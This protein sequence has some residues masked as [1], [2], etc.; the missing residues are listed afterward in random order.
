MHDLLN[1]SSSSLNKPKRGTFTQDFPQYYTEGIYVSFQIIWLVIQTLRG[2]WKG[3]NEWSLCHQDKQ[4]TTKTAPYLLYRGE[5]APDMSNISLFGSPFSGM[6][7][8]RPKS[9][10]FT[11]RYEVKKRIRSYSHRLMQIT[12]YQSSYHHLEHQSQCWLALDPW[13]W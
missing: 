11:V 3:S 8:A 12:A 10:I 7:R 2:H 1:E 13:I 9:N 4:V 5:P 6:I